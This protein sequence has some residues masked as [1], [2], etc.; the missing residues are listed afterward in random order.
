VLTSRS[1]R[2]GPIP[3]AGGCHVGNAVAA[4]GAQPQ[5]LELATRPPVLR[6][7]AYYAKYCYG[8]AR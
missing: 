6:A 1:G 5:Y 8:P 2:G 7:T 3:A 4:V